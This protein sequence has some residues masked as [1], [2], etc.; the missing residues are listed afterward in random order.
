[1][2]DLDAPLNYWYRPT[3]AN[4]HVHVTHVFFVTL[5]HGAKA[6]DEEIEKCYATVSRDRRLNYYK[7]LL[8]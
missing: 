1:M 3:L 8:L 2:I 5:D 4:Y 7:S 6:R